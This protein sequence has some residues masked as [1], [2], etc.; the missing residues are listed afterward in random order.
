[1]SVKLELGGPMINMYL[2]DNPD[3]YCS[4]KFGNLNWKSF[5]T[6]SQ[7]S[8][9]ADEP[10][11]DEIN[12]HNK[13]PTVTVLKQGEKVIGLSPVTDYIWRPHKLESLSLYDWVRNC[14]QEERKKIVKEK[15]NEQ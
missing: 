1:L 9:M 13:P 2:L 11:S 7:N 3:H 12:P 14:V 8:G 6:T 5:V 10:T 4:H 15:R